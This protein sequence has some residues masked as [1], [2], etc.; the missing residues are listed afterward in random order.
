MNLDYRKLEE[1][2]SKENVKYDEPMSKYTTAKIGGPAD[3]LVTPTSTY[4]IINS[5]KFAKENNLKITVI[6]NGSKLIVRD[7]GIRG[8]VIKITSKLSNYEV[9]GE[10]II[11]EAGI[12]LPRLAIIAKDNSLSG[13]EFAAGIPGC[14]GG[15]VF[16]N[17]GA[18][19]SE[20]SAIVEETTYLDKNLKIKIM[21]AKDHNFG[22]RTSYFKENEEDMDIILSVKLKL[23]KGDKEEIARK[24]KENNDSRR[25]KQPLEWPSAGSTFKRPPGYF[26]GKLIDDAGLRGKRIGGAM[27]S[28]KHS[29]FIVNVDNAKAKDVLDLIELIQT[30]VKE[31]FDVDLEPEIKIIGG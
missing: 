11:A 6:G 27:V 22:Y 14:L 1:Y 24:N 2:I 3:I 12:T 4:D 16:M 21:K 30:V 9:K 26:V 7:E 18:Y 29:G 15:S 25:S 17:A 23:V 31:K 5:V 28:E 20:M 10:Y 13:L 19:G 8:L